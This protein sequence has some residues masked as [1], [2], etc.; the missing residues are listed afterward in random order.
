MTIL[1]AD[2][3]IVIVTAIP[4]I[5][6]V[7]PHNF[8]PIWLR[9]CDFWISIAGGKFHGIKWVCRSLQI[10]CSLMKQRQL[11]YSFLPA[12]ALLTFYGH[13]LEVRGE[14]RFSGILDS[15]TW[16]NKQKS[17]IHSEPTGGLRRISMRR[18]LGEKPMSKIWM[19]AFTFGLFHPVQ[20]AQQV[21]RPFWN[22][23]IYHCFCTF[24]YNTVFFPTPA[25]SSLHSSL[26]QTNST[27][28]LILRQEWKVLF[29]EIL[30]PP[31]GCSLFIV[32]RDPPRIYLHCL[33]TVVLMFPIC[34]Q[35]ESQSNSGGWWH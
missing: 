13:I 22:K 30:C 26:T 25:H 24:L 7:S 31:G 15:C 16:N 10:L 18:L 2:Q 32:V 20:L 6:S 11:P 5:L 35:A 14:E 23:W 17:K 28:C 29:S 4:G 1:H 9:T 33:L 19:T 34:S 21:R 3:L 12:F 8:Q 27:F